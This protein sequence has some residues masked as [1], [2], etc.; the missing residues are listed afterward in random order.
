MNFEQWLQSRLTAHGFPVG[1]IDGKVGPVTVAAIKAFQKARGLEVTGAANG[2]VIQ[3]LRFPSSTVSPEVQS[4]LP[5]RDISLDVAP[6][7][8]KQVWPRQDIVPGFFGGVGLHQSSIE[9]PFDMVLAW[10]RSARVKKITL[11]EKVAQSALSVLEKVGQYYS[12]SEREA[13]GLNI[14]GGSLNVRRMRGGTRYS[15]H[16]WG[17]AMD[18]DP[19]R[20]QLQAHRPAARLSHPD[21][22]MFWQLWEDAG[23]LSLGRAK[24]FDWMHVQAAR[25]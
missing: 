18:F 4:E 20:N 6:P 2:T 7:T 23:W 19:E 8:L 11:H 12:A 22:E 13:L 16:S 10:D 3:F 9:A 5:K 1:E 15:M 25:L 24:D 21:A 17:I 14:F